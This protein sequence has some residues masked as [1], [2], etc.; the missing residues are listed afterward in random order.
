MDQK[1]K[2]FLLSRTFI[3]MLMMMAPVVLPL[4]GYEAPTA[5][6]IK[7][8]EDQIYGLLDSGLALVGAALVVWGRVSASRPLRML[9]GKP[10]PDDINTLSMLAPIV[11]VAGGLLLSGCAQGVHLPLDPEA[12]RIE[13]YNKACATYTATL[14]SLAALPLGATTAEQD[15]TVD[16]MIGFA[17]PICEAQAPPPEEETLNALDR[18]VWGLIA[19]E[20]EAG[21]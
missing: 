9:P 6:E 3:G 14:N 7:G 1:P 5:D 2:W 20:R 21:S 8:I 18:T 17:A 10:S 19:I 13:R 4:L 12:A 11:I 16:A 15:A